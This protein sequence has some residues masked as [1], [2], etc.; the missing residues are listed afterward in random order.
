MGGMRGSGSEKRKLQPA[1][2]AAMLYAA[3]FSC[4]F[5]GV[6]FEV[7]A[8]LAGIN[9]KIALKECLWKSETDYSYF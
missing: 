2:P 9:P 1:N 6:A 8:C 5:E 4:K 3:P 7:L